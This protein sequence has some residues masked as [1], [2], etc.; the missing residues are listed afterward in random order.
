M[1]GISKI[2]MTADL[3]D[4]GLMNSYQAD[5]E[6]TGGLLMEFYSGRTKNTEGRPP[7]DIRTYDFQDSLGIEYK[8]TDHGPADNMEA[9]NEIDAILGGG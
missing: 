3:S 8:R 9:C 6:E 2:Y 5:R 1:T 7:R 4:Q